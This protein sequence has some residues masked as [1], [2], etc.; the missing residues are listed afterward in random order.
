MKRL[1]RKKALTRLAK[2]TPPR[3]PTILNRGRLYDQLDRSTGAS[4]T[5]IAAP[6]GAGKTTLVASYLHTRGHEVLWY[7]LDAGDTDP[8]TLFHY[9]GVAVQ[10]AAP[11][12]RTR[13]PHLT[14]EYLAGLSTFTQR[15]F[16]QLGHR[17]SSPTV[18]VF[19]NYQEVP[20]DSPIHRVL[21]LGVPHLPDHIRVIGLS[22]ERPPA[23]YVR[24]L[25]EQQLATIHAAELELTREEAHQLAQLR[26][27]I[28]P[29]DSPANSVDEMWE[30]TKGWM[31]GFILLW[32]HH[33][34]EKTVPSLAA[35]Q[36]TQ[37]IFD[38][39]AGE[40]MAR[41]SPERQ[42]ILLAVSI[43]SDFTPQMAQRLSSQSEAAD[44]LEQLHQSHYFVERREDRLGW[45]R[46]HPLF[47]EFLLRRA[48]QAWTPASMR[49]MRRQAA[50]LLVE[51][52]QAEQAITVLQQ[53]KAWDDYRALVRVQAPQVAQ[54]GRM[55]TLE[56]WIRELPDA[57]RT[58]DPWM[59]FWLA[60]SRLLVAPQEATPL[61][62][63]A[64][65]RFQQQGERVGMLLAWSGAVQAILVAWTGMK[66]LHNLVRAFQQMHPEGTAYPS[67][68][69]ESVVAQ[70]MVGVYMHMYPDRPQARVWLDRAVGLAHALP[71]SMRGAEMVN[72]TLFYLQLN[73]GQKAEDIFAHQQRRWTSRASASMRIMM[74]L[75]E[76][77]LSWWS[78]DT[79]RCRTT[80]QKAL[81]LA[82]QEGLVV[83]NGLL[84]AINIYNKLLFGQTQQAR[85]HLALMQPFA[86]VGSN[87]FIFLMLMGWADLLD[88]HHKEAR[89]KCRQAR[90]ILENEG[91][92]WWHNGLLH[93]LQSQVAM[94]QGQHA[95]AAKL[96]DTVEVV[97][98]T[99]PGLHTF[100]ICLSRAQ[101]AFQAGDERTGVLWLERLLGA[102]ENTN[103]QILFVG[104][105]PAQASG[106]FGKAL[107]L[108]I[109]VPYVT[110]FIR[111]WRLKPPVD[112]PVP[113]NW[114]WRVKIHTFGKLIV[115]VDGKPLEKQRKAPH[116]LL[117]LLTA[118]ITFGGSD[119]PVS[120]LM[121]TL[122]PEVEGNTAHENFK[123]SI[124]RLRKLL[125]VDT[126]I[127]WQDGK[128]SLNRDLCWVD[129]LTFDQH[130]DAEDNRAVALYKGP[131]LGPEEVPVW[132]EFR[133]DQERTRFIRLIN[134]QCN[135]AQTTGNV[136]LAIQ[137][138]ERAIEVD[139]VAEPLYHQLIPLLMAQGRK[140]EAIA[141]YNG[142]RSALA[143]WASRLPSPELQTLVSAIPPQ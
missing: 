54:Q 86:K 112:G 129:A 9:L 83:W 14:P 21:S 143:R 107:E 52:Q 96:L 91:F 53:A 139:P 115:E 71:M 84:H 23:D 15:F 87:Y 117:D 11:H 103:Q 25:A 49:D 65:T 70:A 130:V 100:G 134:G 125:T 140:A 64:M 78:G 120:R 27:A 85:D 136:E 133:R 28:A 4:L 81:D 57:Q 142:C 141:R 108:D 90:G 137:S 22:R 33:E 94:V 56:T 47:Q 68:E 36:T 60:N 39:L 30:R 6:P 75:T 55:H 114:P 5:W 88:G 8:S 89:E 127:Q 3:L 24:L 132:A 80:V 99:L 44:I 62:E 123:K 42:T 34:Q 16:E 32:Q 79:E 106:L 105:V 102:Q 128:I 26:P 67:L 59:D 58:A 40:V 98:Q 31:A 2:L 19:D 113:E 131:F 51:A 109:E 69:V 63:S 116:R 135:Y 72:T 74:G 66:H 48:E 118:I 111:K 126:A 46:F 1:Q 13:L 37:A 29:S 138:L 104:W 101:L 38:Y 124:A 95:E 110:D 122:W 61:Y 12:F 18:L 92:V 35:H 82:E 73:D 7:R 119:V 10:T 20:Q 97:A 76:S 77:L 41:F 17:F 121:D 93:L 45:Y 43:L 50:A